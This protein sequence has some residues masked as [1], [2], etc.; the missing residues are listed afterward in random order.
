MQQYHFRSQKT[1]PQRN[2]VNGNSI[3]NNNDGGGGSS[4]NEWHGSGVSVGPSILTGS[5][6][7]LYN[8]RSSFSLS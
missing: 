2:A 8:V 1:K 3:N 5:M 4:G 7:T 6:Y